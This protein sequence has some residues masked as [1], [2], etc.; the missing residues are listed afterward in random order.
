MRL[1]KHGMVLVLVL[2]AQG[3]PATEE[4]PDPGQG[5]PAQTAVPARMTEEDALAA[6]N[7][8]LAKRAVA[9]EFAGAM[10]ITKNGAAIFEAA[11]GYADIENKVPNTLDT[12]F[13]IG[14][15]G[16]MFT[17]TAVL[18]L[19]QAGS[20]ELDAPLG[21]YLSDYPNKDVAK[22]TVHQ[23]LTHAGGT[24]NIFGP[25]ELA[26]F[27]ANRGN[28]E[29]PKDYIALFGERGPRF[30]PG[31]RWEYSNYGYVLLGRI[32][33][34][35]SGQG[36]YDYVREHIFKPAGMNS[37]DSYAIDQRVPKMATGYTRLAPGERLDG[38]RT[39]PPAGPLRPNEDSLPYRGSP[40]GGGYS[41]VDDLTRFAEAITSHRLLDARHTELLTTGKV[42][43]P[44]PS[45][46]YAYG[47]SD[48]RSQDGV[49]SIGHN[50]GAPGMNGELRILPESGYVVAVLA[51]RD[52]P[53]A[54]MLIQFIGDRLPAK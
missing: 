44:M 25:E 17:A 15:M 19:V 16:K 33:E 36:Y 11:R 3:C 13:D 8:E 40:A 42:D 53:A 39:E 24:G 52:P 31:S 29:E 28:L 2:A 27:N 35:A 6:L 23:L 46:K 20:V 47:F 45:S 7:E 54:Q 22:V 32:I 5:G 43:E 10:M 18:Q 51:N 14:S 48:V 12:I 37:T 30:E 34:L 50:G 38:V 49:R 9:D 21:K 26:V 4:Q 1:M 41:T